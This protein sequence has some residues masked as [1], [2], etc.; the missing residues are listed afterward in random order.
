MGQVK[1]ISRFFE[2][3]D[4]HILKVYEKYGGYQ[5][6]RR[7]VEEKWPEQKII[8][9]V[10]ASNLRGLGGAGFPTGVKWGFVPRDEKGPKY[11]V[12]NADESEPGTFK[13]RHCILHAPHLLIEGIIIAAMSIGA[14]DAF[15]Y[16]RGEYGEPYRRLEHALEEARKA[17]YIG[18]KIFGS[19]RSL[20]IHLHR[21]AGA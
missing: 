2:I 13:D 7:V 10:K 6:S 11:L 4:S 17:H 1:L 9:T 8:D 12:V 14:K 15:I 19:S 16:I 5:A 21:G 18:K 3:E 20:E